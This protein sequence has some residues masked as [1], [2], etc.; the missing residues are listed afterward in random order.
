ME[1]MLGGG[2]HFQD[3]PLCG[4]SFH[5]SKIAR[6]AS[7]CTG[8]AAEKPPPSSAPSSSSLPSSSSSSASSS[9]SSSA[10]ARGTKRPRPSGFGPLRPPGAADIKG[11]RR[12]RRGLDAPLAEY[13]WLVVLDFEWT[14]DRARVTPFAE[15]IEWSCVL[16]DLRRRPAA[17]VSELQQYVKPLH[18]PTL[19]PFCKELTAITQAQVDAGCTLLEAIE[20]FE[21]WLRNC[22]VSVGRP[23]LTAAATA[24]AAAAE[25]PE[26]AV[27]TWSDA[28]LGAT[29]PRQMRALGIARRPH[30][31]AWINL[32]LAYQAVYR[33]DPRGLQRCVEAIGLRFRGRAHSGLVDAQNTAAMAC[34]MANRENHRFCRTTRCLQADDW[35][36]VGSSRPPPPRRKKG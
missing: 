13:K 18:N 7:K 22:G 31:D 21:R 36:M 33:R 4:Q 14:C 9:S 30:F 12:R 26:F 10:P 16:V 2:T 29:L 28:D 3:C 24:A 5:R 17:I 32:K 8:V 20:G 35:T 25:R 23:G 34:A 11:R 6:H 27:V 19:S 15:I 1:G